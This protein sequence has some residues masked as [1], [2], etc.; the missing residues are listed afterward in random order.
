M[1]IALAGI[2]L[3]VAFQ[4]FSTLPLAPAPAPLPP[5]VPAFG[6]DY[7]PPGHSS[8]ALFSRDSGLLTDGDLGW[9]AHK[10]TASAD[11][12][13]M[14]SL[15]V[16]VIRLV[17]WPAPSGYSPRT[18]TSQALAALKL[19][20][21]KRHLPEFVR[22]AARRDIKV[23]VGF[24]N[25]Y[26]RTCDNE[27]NPMVCPGTTE[28]TTFYWKR[29]LPEIPGATEDQKFN[30]LVTTGLD[31]I[32]SIYSIFEDN[33]LMDRVVYFDLHAEL[34]NGTPRLWE[35]IN[36]VFSQTSFI[37]SNKLAI[38][39]L[40]C[41][42]N[43]PDIPG[44]PRNDDVFY[45]LR[46]FS[47]EF[48]RRFSFVDFHSYP[49]LQ[50]SRRGH[51]ANPDIVGCSKRINA[52]LPG[53]IQILGEFG[54]WTPGAKN[55]EDRQRTNLLAV[56]EKIELTNIVAALHWQLYD[57]TPTPNYNAHFGL[58][59]APDSPKEGLAAIISKQCLYINNDFEEVEFGNAPRSWYA[60]ST[61]ASRPTLR[62]LQN[63]D[64]AATGSRFARLEIPASSDSTF[65]W[66]RS[67]LVA[68]RPGER[69][70]V[71]AFLRSG[72]IKNVRINVREFDGEKTFLSDIRG[73]AVKLD[74]WRWHQYIRAANPLPDQP[75]FFQLSPETQNVMII[76]SA[77]PEIGSAAMLDVD[78]LSISQ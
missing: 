34:Y 38:G 43:S 49:V 54:A 14:K 7:W 11:M 4:N 70:Y 48:F 18:S 76:V 19:A 28:R 46:S 25:D 77:E 8:N 37:P 10:F 5:T 65:A 74:G 27:E 67:A 30:Y 53:K 63:S 24:T 58:L 39:L 55:A 73:R 9:E 52:K 69:L 32:H 44:D 71:N 51:Q 21:L 33:D 36:R 62:A 20:E 1:G 42:P 40:R 3:F 22:M 68:V 59:Y 6:L 12:D 31:W 2:L 17:F 45:F 35:Y 72:S 23:I 57:G 47:S 60:E 26:L 41:H 50:D 78:S 61:D 13:F 15:G 29:F 56:Q 66:M 16:K 64:Y 75:F